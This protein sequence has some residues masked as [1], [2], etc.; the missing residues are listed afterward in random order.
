MAVEYPPEDPT[1]EEAQSEHHCHTLPPP[2]PNKTSL[3]RNRK[4]T[5]AD[6]TPNSQINEFIDFEQFSE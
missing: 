1:G 3:L 6:P 4:P 5:K 2:P